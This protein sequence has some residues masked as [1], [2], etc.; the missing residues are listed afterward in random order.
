VRDGNAQRALFPEDVI[1][2]SRSL[3][4]R[5]REH[6]ARTVGGRHGQPLPEQLRHPAQGARREAER[7]EP[8]QVREA[9]AQRGVESGA[10]LRQREGIAPRRGPA[11]K[12][13]KRVPLVV[14]PEARAAR[15]RARVPR[16]RVAPQPVRARAGQVHAVAGGLSGH[17]GYA[18]RQLDEPRQPA[19][20]A[21]SLRRSKRLG[22]LL[23]HEE[24]GLAAGGDR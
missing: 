22:F 19:S 2:H 4:P 1:Q 24:D 14:E 11:R 15:Q 12:R 17:E 18:E 9:L 5:G 8:G 6:V 10:I 13:W 16:G 7:L 23:R 21:A 20:H 3:E